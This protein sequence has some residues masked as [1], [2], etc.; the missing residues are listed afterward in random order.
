MEKPRIAIFHPLLREGGGSEAC[1]LF[2]AEALQ[3]EQEVTLVTTG[4]PDLERLNRYY[5][6]NLDKD[7]IKIVSFPVPAF[8]RTRLSALRSARAARYCR[9]NAGRFDLMISTY[10]FMDFGLKGIQFIADFS[11][12]DGLRERDRVEPSSLIRVLHRNRIIRAPYLSLARVLSRASREGWKR[13]LTIANSDWTARTL[14]EAFGTDS[15]TIY[16]PV[17]DV[18][19]GSPWE[20]REAGFIYLGR[21]SPEKDLESVIAILSAVRDEGFHIHL[22]IVGHG[23][24]SGYLRRIEE[25]AR[26]N[27]D[28]VFLEGKLVGAEKAAFVGRHQFGI[29]ACWNE[30]F[31]ISIAEMVKAGCLVWVP[32][33]GGQTE[34]VGR[35]ELIYSSRADAAAKIV[36][37]LRDAGLQESLCRGLED[38]KKMFSVS[39]FAKEVRAVVSDFLKER[40]IPGGGS[41]GTGTP[42]GPEKES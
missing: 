5:G 41:V 31:G 21:I 38:R 16:P 25:L 12:D 17:A 36:R 24:D 6:V 35:P 26:Q 34:I 29:S 37:V 33:S 7:R 10:N 15:R 14:R 3:E 32:A 8:A 18:P 28:W 2:A 23:N 27:A 13:N 9:K 19:P 40:R 4:R 39:R 42:D 11:F 20:E 22:H 30:A 1:A